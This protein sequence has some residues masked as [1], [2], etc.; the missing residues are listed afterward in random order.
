MNVFYVHKQMF[1]PNVENFGYI[2][3]VIVPFFQVGRGLLSTVIRMYKPPSEQ[4]RDD[5]QD[6]ITDGQKVSDQ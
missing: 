3:V 6:R 5:T 2:W 1:G 4:G